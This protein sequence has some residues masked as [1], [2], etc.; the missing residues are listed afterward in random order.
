MKVLNEKVFDDEVSLNVQEIK[1]TLR[2][3]GYHSSKRKRKKTSAS[4]WMRNQRMEW[5]PMALRHSHNNQWSIAVE[6]DEGSVF[7]V[8]GRWASLINHDTGSLA[9][10]KQVRKHTLPFSSI[11]W[12][13]RSVAQ[14]KRS[15][16]RTSIT[17]QS[18]IHLWVGADWKRDSHWCLHLCWLKHFL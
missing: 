17:W 4:E 10:L 13:S 2:S 15:S 18:I 8:Y 11:A 7:S 14:Y 9:S 1:Q 12:R 6:K 5:E 16:S 3:I